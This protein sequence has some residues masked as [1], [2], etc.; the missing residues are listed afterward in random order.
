MPVV[1]ETSPNVDPSSQALRPS[2]QADVTGAPE[3][4][5]PS[6]SAG[7]PNAIANTVDITKVKVVFSTGM[8][9]DNMPVNDLNRISINQNRIVCHVKMLDFRL[10]RSLKKSVSAQKKC[11]T[12]RPKSWAAPYSRLDV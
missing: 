5:S 6:S 12:W 9:S 1:R 3:A 4:Y 7:L 8:D 2:V 10:S 11:L